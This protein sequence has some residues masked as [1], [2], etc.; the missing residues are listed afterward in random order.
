MT[1]SWSNLATELLQRFG[2]ETRYAIPILQAIQ[3]EQGYIPIPLLEAIASK[4]HHLQA[5]QLYGVATFYSQFTFTPK[6]VHTIKVLG[7]LLAIAVAGR[8]CRRSGR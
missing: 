1:P 6:G 8:G 7:G 2:D 5:N 3:T 4:A